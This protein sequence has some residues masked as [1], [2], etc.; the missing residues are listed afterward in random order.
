MSLENNLQLLT[1][2]KPTSKPVLH[3]YPLTASQILALD[4][5]HIYEFFFKKKV[6]TPP[7]GPTE[8]GE[9][10]DTT[11][12]TITQSLTFEERHANLKKF[13]T[14][15]DLEGLNYTSA[16]TIAFTRLFPQNNGQLNP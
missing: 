16:G 13:F 5:P 6:A 7:Q 15:L 9:S 4:V 1:K 8:E 12:S 3:R 10:A 2:K 11:S 14:F